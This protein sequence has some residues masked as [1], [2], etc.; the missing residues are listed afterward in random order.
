MFGK[1]LRLYKREKLRSVTA[2]DRLFA[3]RVSKGERHMDKWGE[4]SVAIAY[5]LRMVFGTNSQR[6]GA[7]IQFLVSVP[8]KRIRKAVDRVTVRRRIR[9]AFRAERGPIELLSGTKP[10]LD[11][12]FIYIAD[13][14][15]DYSKIRRAMHRLM[16]LLDAFTGD[17]NLIETGHEHSS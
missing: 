3:I 8:K 9:E 5:P 16:S 12:A 14:L 17:Q 1:G 2:I 11:V 7:A 4:V 15:T 6:G 10:C 13:G